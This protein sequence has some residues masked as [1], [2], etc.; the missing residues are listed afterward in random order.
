VAEFVPALFPPTQFSRQLPIVGDFT[1]KFVLSVQCTDF[2]PSWYSLTTAVKYDHLAFRG[3]G[4]L[5]CLFLL[6]IYIAK[7]YRLKIKWTIKQTQIMSNLT[8][9][10]PRRSFVKIWRQIND[11]SCPRQNNLIFVSWEKQSCFGN[12]PSKS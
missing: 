9:Q 3:G 8:R 5:L 12:A 11:L 10:F 6:K 1:I 7:I 4:R 2:P